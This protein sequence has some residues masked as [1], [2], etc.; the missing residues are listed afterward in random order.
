MS[1]NN[2]QKALLFCGFCLSLTACKTAEERAEVYFA[3]SR[4]F[5]EVGDFDRAVVELRNVFELMPN[6][7]E[8]RRTMASIM[9]EQGH[10]PDAYVQYTRLVEQ[11][12]GDLAAR[13][14]LAEL[15]FDG[16][17]WKE[18]ERH[19][20]I[21]VNL[22]PDT[23]RG[24]AIEIALKYQK[25][26]EDR[27]SVEIEVL[28]QRANTLL[29]E[30]KKNTLLQQ[31]IIDYLVRSGEQKAALDQLRN[32]IAERPNDRRFYD[33][34]LILLRQIGDSTAIE[35]HLRDI[36][37]QFQEDLEAKSDLLRH[38]TA[39]GDLDRAEDFLRS[40]SDPADPDPVLFLNLVNFL[41]EF[42]GPD[43][44][45]QEI[46]KAL[47]VNPEPDR[48]RLIRAGLDFNDGY[49]EKAI[50]DLQEI[51]NRR[52]PSELTDE[53][54]IILSRLLTST[55]DPSGAERLV[56]E[57]LKANPNNIAALKIKAAKQIETDD[58]EG[59]VESL[60][61]VLNAMPD[62]VEAL[63]LMAEAYARIGSQ[64][65]VH[66]Y[67]AQSVIVSNHA[68]EP[69][70][71]YARLL[72]ADKNYLSA[73]E[74]LIQ[75]LHQAP[76]DPTILWLLG[77]IFIATE[78][79]DRAAMAADQL[80]QI[81]SEDSVSAAN[82]LQVQIMARQAG[83]DGA[84][85][86]L[87]E[88][89]HAED[90]GM[91]EKVALLRARLSS[92]ETTEAL[93]IAEKLLAADPENPQLRFLLANTKAATG[94]LGAAELELQKLIKDDPTQVG[95][96][97]QLYRLVQ[98]S[99]GSEASSAVLAA[100][101]DEVPDAPMLLWAQA[102]ELEQAG[103]IDAAIKI[104][105]DLYSSNSASA[106]FA[107]NLASILATHKNDEVSLQRAWAIARRLHGSDAPAFQ[108]TYGWLAFRRGDPETALTY[109][110]KAAVGL[111]Q[112]AIV[113]YHLAE[114]YNSL[115]RP[116]EALAT[117]KRALQVSG[118]NNPSN[119]MQRAHEAMTEL[120]AVLESSNGE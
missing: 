61:G 69:S 50:T 28:I 102:N 36:V 75:A 39:Q 31:I 58:P 60:R 72:I 64:D 6:H 52:E 115:G 107:N 10:T 15:A 41:N 48:L 3:S 44:A 22:A 79:L 11:E 8:A 37:S 113:Q 110:E 90:A 83:A 7:V 2:L 62:D 92:G 9:L 26:I 106:I 78:D 18:F 117:Y 34:R 88:L 120:Q 108:D 118:D 67:L 65:L 1:P 46:D 114:V 19:G 104:Y 5:I 38:L 42:H 66:D 20:T 25:A 119:Q 105:D 53:A 17:N 35:T 77:S 97:L 98:V 45:R 100:A 91:S 112:N 93:G 4:E 76:G 55:G 43:A 116:E 82:Q 27:D 57:V 86:F 32:V 54:K 111:P 47:D 81:G 59:A 40:I 51:I 68:A 85:S 21:A 80:R 14:M 13:T 70:L 99:K 96:W 71:R 109:L 89:A 84:L 74:I 103:D 101:L 94:E 49:R 87:E 56:S 12:P 23:P 63:N 30:I 24:Q 33:Q 16:G 29:T 95:V 73:K